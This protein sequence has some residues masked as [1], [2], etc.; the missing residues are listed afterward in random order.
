MRTATTVAFRPLADRLLVRVIE[1]EAITAGGVM[2]VSRIVWE[3]ITP[4]APTGEEVE[5]WLMNPTL[6]VRLM[7]LEEIKAMF[8]PACTGCTRHA[9]RADCPRH[10]G[11]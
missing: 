2:G 9:I 5:A 7:P 10:A 8:G 4:A 6:P 3:P 11:K 1:E